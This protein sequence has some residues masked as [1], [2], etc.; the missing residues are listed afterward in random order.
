MARPNNETLIS[1]PSRTKHRYIRVTG[2]QEGYVV[3]F[4]DRHH[5]E[6]SM[7]FTTYQ[8]ALEIVTIYLGMV[9]DNE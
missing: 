1:T 6:A 8:E 3:V 4:T 9:V 5:S 7:A 2:Q